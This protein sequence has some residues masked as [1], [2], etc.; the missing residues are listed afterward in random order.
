[1]SFTLNPVVQLAGMASGHGC[2]EQQLSMLITRHVLFERASPSLPQHWE[3]NTL[4]DLCPAS[5]AGQ[6]SIFE[7]SPCLSSAVFLPPSFF[8]HSSPPDPRRCNFSCHSCMPSPSHFCFL[9]C[10]LNPLRVTDGKSG[11]KKNPF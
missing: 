4:C 6:H 2:C 11:E 10:S 3:G 8:R 5:S 1:M 7:P 9:S